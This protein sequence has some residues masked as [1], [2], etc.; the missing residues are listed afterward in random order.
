MGIISDNSIIEPQ[1]SNNIKE[2]AK[3]NR[4]SQNLGFCQLWL[5]TIIVIDNIKPTE[6]AINSTSFITL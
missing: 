1:A 4:P 2:N 6:N 3:I 5:L